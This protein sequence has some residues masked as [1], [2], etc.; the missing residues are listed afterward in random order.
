MLNDEGIV[1]MFEERDEGAIEGARSLYGGYCRT[2]ARAI[3]NDASEAEDCLTDACM[4]AWNRIPPEKPR[5]LLAYLAKIT[6]N[7]AIDL[8]RKKNAKMRGANMEGI[9]GE[10]V[11]CIPDGEGDPTDR[12]ALREALNLFL[13]KESSLSRKLFVRRYF[14]AST[15]AEIAKDYGLGEASVKTALHRLRERLRNFLTEK[16]IQV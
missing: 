8:Y 7:L 11:E 6:R 3:L 2:V 12:L 14:Y 4:Q 15:V 10:L 9:L 1:K 5:S 16:G 13:T